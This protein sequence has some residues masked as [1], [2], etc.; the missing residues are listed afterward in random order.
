MQIEEMDLPQWRRG[1]LLSGHH[2]FSSSVC[3]I[4]MAH[5]GGPR[6]EFTRVAAGENVVSAFSGATKFR[7]V[8]QQAYSMKGL[9][10]LCSR[11]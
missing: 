11:N 6:V 7:Q 1:R 2:F 10:S 4:Q 9:R 3:D 5:R 8:E